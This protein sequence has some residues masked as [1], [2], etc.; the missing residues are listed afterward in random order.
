MATTDATRPRVGVATIIWRNADRK[1]LLL[2]KGHSDAAN[3]EIYAVTGGH[4]DSGEKLH[5]AALREAQEEAGVEVTDLQLISVY[6]FFNKEKQ[7]SYVTVG[8]AGIW[9]AGEPT[10]LETDKKIDWGWYTPERALALPL[11]EPDR[12][13]IERAAAGGALYDFETD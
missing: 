5:E 4:W 1:E 9:S 3:D 11:F 6:D 8:F 12:K 13:L 7:R 2:G 10:V